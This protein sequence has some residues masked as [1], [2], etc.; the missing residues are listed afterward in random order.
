MEYVVFKNG[1]TKEY[2]DY[3]LTVVQMQKL[4]KLHF[5]ERFERIKRLQIGKL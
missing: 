5:L 4:S 1:H 3:V 2:C